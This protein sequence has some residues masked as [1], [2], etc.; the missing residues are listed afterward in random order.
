MRCPAL[1]RR[2]F[3][4]RG[5][6]Y[7]TSWPIRTATASRQGKTGAPTRLASSSTF[8]RLARRY[9][10]VT[11]WEVPPGS[12]SWRVAI[13]AVSA[14]VRSSTVRR[15]R[16]VSP[17]PLR[18][19]R[20]LPGDLETSHLLR[21]TAG[22]RDLSRPHP[23]RLFVG[24]IHDGE[25]AEVPLRLGERAVGEQWCATRRITTEHRGSGVP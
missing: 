5:M 9:P 24:H 11:S 15:K 2:A 19:L 21:P 13:H 10:A 12:T 8:R 20:K 18:S 16:S 1:N 22:H 14:A 23:R 3:G 17:A 6:R 4:T 7:W 25:A